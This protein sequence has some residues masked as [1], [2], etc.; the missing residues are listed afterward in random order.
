MHPMSILNGL[1]TKLATMIV[2]L[3]QHHIVTLLKAIRDKRL[4]TD[5]IDE[6]KGLEQITI[7][8]NEASNKPI[9]Q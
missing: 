1:Q 6:L 2:E 4:N 3:K 7:V 8:I 9:E 5:D